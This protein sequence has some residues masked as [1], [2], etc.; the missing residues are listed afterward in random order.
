M[1]STLLVS[2]SEQNKIDLT[3]IRKIF[4]ILICKQDQYAINKGNTYFSQWH[5]PFPIQLCLII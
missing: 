1:K 2:V 4:A 3:I 5:A